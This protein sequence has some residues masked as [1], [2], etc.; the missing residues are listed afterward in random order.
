MIRVRQQQRELGQVAAVAV[1]PAAAMVDLSSGLPGSIVPV[2][3]IVQVQVSW[4]GNFGIFLNEI[5]ENF[6]KI[7]MCWIFVL[8]MLN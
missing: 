7:I 2:T 6:Q 5:K 1:V 4:G 8:W 3:V